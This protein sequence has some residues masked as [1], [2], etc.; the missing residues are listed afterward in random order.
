MSGPPQDEQHSTG[1]RGIS[2]RDVDHSILMKLRIYVLVFLGTAAAAVVDAVRGTSLTWLFL[3][4]GLM[5]GVVLG[6]VASRMQ[7]LDWD[8]FEQRMVGRFDVLGVLV[9]LAYIAFALNRSR[10]VE[11]WVPAVHA[12]A[13]SL[14]V[15]AGLMFGQVL[16]TRRGLINLGRSLH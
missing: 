7:R 4:A 10:I 6:M 8:S 12:P 11:A 2:R 15:L 9:L 3:A 13:T 16:G 14:A 5:A 1:P